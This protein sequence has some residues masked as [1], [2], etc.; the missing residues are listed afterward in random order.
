MNSCAR[1]SEFKRFHNNVKGKL[2]VFQEQRRFPGMWTA[3]DGREQRVQRPHGSVPVFYGGWAQ[4]GDSRSP[5][6]A[7]IW[8]L[9]LLLHSGDRPE[10]DLPDFLTLIM[11]QESGETVPSVHFRRHG[12]V[13]RIPLLVEESC[14]WPGLQS[15]ALDNPVVTNMA[16]YPKSR[17]EKA[18]PHPEFVAEVH[19][20]YKCT[21]HWREDIKKAFL[22]EFGLDIGR[23]MRWDSETVFCG[24]REL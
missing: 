1:N 21:T 6:D 23:G 8:Q 11:A 15:W 10:E 13:G 5:S 9:A 3:R 20:S 18:S 2:L 17:V 4:I 12:N 7:G 19:S 24:Q 14:A 22:E 16:R